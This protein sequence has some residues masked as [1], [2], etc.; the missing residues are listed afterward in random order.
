MLDEVT[1]CIL[2][3]GA[4]V[5]EGQVY[6]V[7]DFGGRT[8]DVS[9]VRT[10]DLAS[11]DTRPCDVLGR[12]GEEIGGSLVDQWML[13]GGLSTPSSSHRSSKWQCAPAR[14]V[15]GLFCQRAMNFSGVMISFPVPPR[16]AVS[17]PCCQAR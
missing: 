4:R 6:V 15:S 8:L 16:S 12:A 5:R 10:R 14:S 2:G 9:V 7:F 1:A 17:P 3:H 11:G 13:C